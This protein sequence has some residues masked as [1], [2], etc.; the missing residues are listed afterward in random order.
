MIT[1]AFPYATAGPANL[2]HAGWLALHAPSGG[3]WPRQRAV[4]TRRSEH[5]LPRAE[6]VLAVTARP[7]P[8]SA[9]L[10]ALLY[11]FGRSGSRVCLLSLTRG[12]ASRLNSTIEP[13]HSVRPWELQVA[14]ALLGISSVAVADYPD[15]QLSSCGLGALTERVGRAIAE[16]SVDLVLVTDPAEGGLDDAVVAMAAC[17]A[18]EEE[19]L[20]ALARTLSAV[21]G[22][23]Q[24]DLGEGAAQARAVQRSA[25]AAHASQSDALA[26]L[27]SR[28]RLLGRTEWLRW[29]VQP[30]EPRPLQL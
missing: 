4:R 9:D 19:R 29:L 13:L 11:T 18:A 16:H 24:V 25:V 12:E 21:R 17:A 14:A 1:T 8:E 15:G 27:A 2:A 22:G 30:P 6:R 5:M 28:L 7:G 26:G 3:N 20:P 10:G 23:W